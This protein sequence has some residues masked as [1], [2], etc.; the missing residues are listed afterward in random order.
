MKS[1]LQDT[2]TRAGE[3]S[4]EYREKLTEIEV[5]RKSPKDLVTEA[6]VAVE[7]YIVEQIKKHYPDHSILGEESGTHSG[8]EYQWI[9]DPID[10]TAGFVHCHPFYSVSVGLKKGDELILGAVFVPVLGELFL[11]QKGDGATLNGTPIHVSTRTNLSECMIGTGFAC[12]REDFTE[13]NLPYFVEIAPKVR[14]MRRH[15]SAAADLA[16]VACGRFDAFWELNLKIYDIAAGAILVQ[17][18]GGKVTDFA[19][20]SEGMPMEVLAASEA[21]YPDLQKIIEK[22]KQ[23]AGFGSKD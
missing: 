6:D 1:F 21:I 14:G 3:I 2:I 18:A 8:N 7:H 17:E 12:L 4:L 13:N 9:I 15:G 5:N 16:Y 11:A 23:Q 19:G 20:G 22:V 10:G